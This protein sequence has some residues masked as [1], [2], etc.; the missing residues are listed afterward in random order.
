LQLLLGCLVSVTCY[1]PVL[2]SDRCLRSMPVQ[3]FTCFGL[4]HHHNRVTY[5]CDKSIPLCMLAGCSLLWEPPHLVTLA[6]TRYSPV[7]LLLQSISLSREHLFWPG[8]PAVGAICNQLPLMSVAS[9]RLLV[10]GISG[11]VVY[12]STRFYSTHRLLWF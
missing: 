6:R 4:S 9:S 10:G 7:L 12:L 3:Q 1:S 5:C 11:C 2:L 8:T